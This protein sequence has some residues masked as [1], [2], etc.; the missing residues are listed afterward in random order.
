VKYFDNPHDAAQKSELAYPIIIEYN[1]NVQIT[2]PPL[3]SE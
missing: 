3:F 1:P 2:P